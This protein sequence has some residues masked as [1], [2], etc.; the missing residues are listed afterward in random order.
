VDG[1]SDGDR[2]ICADSEAYDIGRHL[3]ALEL[4]A[5][6]FQRGIEESRQNGSSGPGGGS[7]HGPPPTEQTFDF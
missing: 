6:P 2:L 4:E 1:G 7:R 3:L 5:T